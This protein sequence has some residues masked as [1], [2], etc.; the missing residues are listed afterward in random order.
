[1]G[2]GSS[3]ST[4]ILSEEAVGKYST[5]LNL[6]PVTSPFEWQISRATA[7]ALVAL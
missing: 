4:T 3:Y 6:R 1:M 2:S 5:G 7:L